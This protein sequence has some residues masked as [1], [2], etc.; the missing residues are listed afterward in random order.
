LTPSPAFAAVVP[1]GWDNGPDDW[2]NPIYNS[3]ILWEGLWY[4]WFFYFLTVVFR[5]TK[6][7]IE[8]YKQ[9]KELVGDMGG[10]EIETNYYFEHNV[11]E[12]VPDV[13]MYKKTQAM[14]DQDIENETRGFFDKKN[15]DKLPR[16]DIDLDI[17][18]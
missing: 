18:K 6:T 11:V 1:D 17:F 15:E 16:T 8:I 12:G 3:E 5:Q 10:E 4:I 7:E 2:E 14:K 9:K 13:K